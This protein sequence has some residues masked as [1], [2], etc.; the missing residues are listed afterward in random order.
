M[1]NYWNLMQGLALVLYA[2]AIIGTARIPRPIGFLM[3]L[4]GL[5]FVVSGWQVG[6]GG[7]NS[8]E[9]L[10]NYTGYTA[11]FVLIVWM[12]VVAWR[13]KESAPAAASTQA[14]REMRIS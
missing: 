9:T 6:T 3:A 1:N 10:T 2:A 5:A 12:L 7:F 8:A 11:L 13:S 14:A 4:S